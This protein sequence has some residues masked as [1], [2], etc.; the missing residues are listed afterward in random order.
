VCDSQKG[1]WEL[2]AFFS[3]DVVKVSGVPVGEDG[4]V[5]AIASDHEGFC[6]SIQDRICSAVCSRLQMFVFADS[7]QSK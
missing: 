1:G 4:T 3:E 6:R 7:F 2:P 5:L